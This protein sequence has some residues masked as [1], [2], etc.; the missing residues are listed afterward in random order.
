VLFRARDEV[1]M[2]PPG[3]TRP[4]HFRAI[5][6]DLVWEWLFL[7]VAAAV[8]A[9]AGRLNALQYLTVQ[10]YLTLMFGALVTLLIVVA[11]WR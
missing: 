5:W 2:P 7:P 8:Q 9:V 6:H 3:D 11:V 10:H 1:E 4:A